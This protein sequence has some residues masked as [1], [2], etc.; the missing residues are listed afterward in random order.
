MPPQR[1]V[2]LLFLCFYLLLFCTIYSSALHL[3][4][5]VLDFLLTF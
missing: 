2:K 5:T 4:S 3:S 1:K